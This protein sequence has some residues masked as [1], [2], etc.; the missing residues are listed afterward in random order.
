MNSH[1]IDKLAGIPCETYAQ[2]D[3]RAVAIG[4]GFSAKSFQHSEFQGLMDPL[5]MVDHFVMTQPTFGTHAH[6]GMSAVTVVFEDSKGA[7]RNRDS[8]GNDIDLAPGDLY[9][10][11][12]ARGA[13]HNEA[14]RPGATTHALQ[15]FVNLPGD[16]RH[17]APS[18]FHLRASDIPSVMGERSSARVVLG[19]ANG[20]SGAAAPDIP[21]S[22]LDLTIQP[23]GHFT[24]HGDA[25]QHAW[26]LGIKGSATVTWRSASIDV[27]PG[28]AIAVAGADDIALSSGRGAHVVL[29]RGQ[30]LRQAFVQRGPFVMDTAAQLDAV[31][32]EYRAGR[33][34]S[35]D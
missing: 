23:G 15:V 1:P 27:E 31:E 8:L 28:K 29:F 34:G 10:F 2:S 26:L 11:K 30:P 19:Q 6:A 25:G 14:P 5:I 7:F 3:G 35:I 21:L 17:D 13:I 4:D 24:H 9:W 16:K 20:V 32:A 12:A 22:L 33:L 18:A